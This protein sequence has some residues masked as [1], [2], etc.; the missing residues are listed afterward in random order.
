MVILV[1]AA[2]W[3]PAYPAWITGVIAWA[4]CLLLLPRLPR[5]Q[6]LMV[7]ALAGIGALGIA[8]GMARGSDGLI[9][10]ALTQNVPLAGM[11]IAVSLLQLIAVSPDAREEPLQRGRGA[12][13]KTM[14]GVH[15]FGAVINYSAVAIFA[16]RLSARTKLTM[17][18]AMGLSQAF[19]VGAIWS[20]F[21]GAM[22]AALTSA[23]EA[24]LTQLIFWGIPVSAIGI[25]V[26]WFTLTSERHGRAEHFVGYPLHLEALWVPAVLAVGVLLVHEWQPRWSVMAI[27]AA[28]ASLVTI[29][30]LLFRHGAQAG[31]TLLRHVH[32]RLPGMNGELTLFLAAGILSAGMNGTIDALDLGLPFAQFG[33]FEASIVLIVMNV[34]A[35]L[36]LHPIILVSVLGPWLL[37][38]QPDQTLLAM[39]FLMSWGIGLTAC[40]MSN[41]MLGMAGRYRLP[42]GQLLALNRRYSIKMTA[43]CIV[44]LYVYAAV[45][46]IT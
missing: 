41:T 10:M 13:F 25:A 3:L 42:F 9:V 39:V 34:C 44:V 35:W 12:L 45:K 30:T 2:V 17:E 6:L 1:V 24:S 26:T 37:P 14:I 46:G 33:A 43:V 4:A 38:L 22:A 5:Q 40:P 27:I 21:Y 7:L 32:T 18:Q 20:P 11:L 23:P 28:M 31:P 8:F 29:A 16:D 15:L 36:G 19:I